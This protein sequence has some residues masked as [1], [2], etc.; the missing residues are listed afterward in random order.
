MQG[1]HLVIVA[2]GMSAAVK[3][4][5]VEWAGGAQIHRSADTAFERRGLGGLEHIRARDDFR[6]KDVEGQIAGIVIGGENAVIE[7]DD[8]VLRTE[9]AHRDLLAL[10][11]GG[12]VYGDAREMLQRVRNVR[13]RE[14][15]KFL[16]IDGIQHHRCIASSLR[17]TSRDWL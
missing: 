4:G 12:A 16:G 3:T 11:A 14:A 9:A 8:V 7:R 17:A 13:I 1:G 6:G 5:V 2:L 10:A 15:P